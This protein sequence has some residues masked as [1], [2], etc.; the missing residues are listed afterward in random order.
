MRL[1]P[2]PS[3]RRLANRTIQLTEETRPLYVHTTN[4]FDENSWSEPVYVDQGGFD[5]DLF[6]DEDNRVYLTTTAG[7][8]Q[9][10]HFGIFANWL[11]E[12]DIETGDALSNR[13]LLHETTSRA[14]SLYAANLAEGSHIYNVNGTYHMITADR[15]TYISH[16]TNSYR[17]ASLDGPWE[18][19]PN[20]PVL[21]NGKDT[22]QPVLSTGHADL[23]EAPDGSWWAVFLAT[24]PKNPDSKFGP[25]QL[26]RETFLCPVTWEDGWPV[27]N[28]NKIIT[29][30]MPGVLYD[31]EQPR[32]WRDD[33][34]GRLADKQYYYLRTPCKDFK[35]F[36]S[37]PGKLGVKGNIFTLSDR[38][39]P[40]ALLRKQVHHNTTFSTEITMFKPEN[41]RQEA[42]VTVYLSTYYHNEVAITKYKGKR[43][44]VLHTRTGPDAV[45]NT[46]YIQDRDIAAS[47]PVKLVIE[48]RENGYRFGYSTRRRDPRWVGFV[49]NINLQTA[50][51]GFQNFV[52]AHFGIYS[53]G[54]G[55]PVLSPAVSASLGRTH[56]HY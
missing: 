3:H 31:L 10:P 38:D 39:T 2:C 18:G 24:R 45:L 16:K 22:S 30:A 42:G 9:T 14:P 17:A 33:F 34:D 32:V 11:S 49:D 43:C 7:D 52:G 20:N 29:E 28:N 8:P 46:T 6:F 44:I 19:N 53:T 26:G 40:A 51:V 54:S 55:L 21:W 36:Q 56:L 13:R 48:A 50:P 15:G 35:D 1:S 5:S 41:N 37:S 4:I 25:A 12:I 23:V 27:F 47:R